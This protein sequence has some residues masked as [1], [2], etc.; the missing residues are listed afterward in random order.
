SSNYDD[1][2]ASQ[3]HKAPSGY[4]NPKDCCKVAPITSNFV[5]ASSHI[6]RTDS[7]ISLIN[8][9]NDLE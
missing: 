4:E 3:D 6:R 9:F 5:L 8:A 2:K 7:Q 1:S